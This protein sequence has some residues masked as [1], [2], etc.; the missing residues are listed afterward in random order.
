MPKNIVVL[1]DGTG[2]DGGRGHDSNV[3]KLYRMLEDRTE[4]QIVYY[5]QG[6]GTD[7]RRVSGNAFGVGFTK[8]IEQCYRFIF[9]NYQAGDKIFLFGFSRGAA[10]VRSLASFIH[11][12]GIL[13]KSR[14]TLVADAFKLYG[15]GEKPKTQDDET[16]LE[17]E[18]R[19][20]LQKLAD[21]GIQINNDASYQDYKALRNDLSDKAIQFTTA[22][23]NMWLKS[24]SWVFGTQ[25]LR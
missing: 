2:Q 6:L 21:R 16:F 9:E 11:Y 3:Y 17:E 24:T 23:P 19:K 8:N 4:N 1:S 7:W 14:A 13:P 20:L 15:L 25:S 12:F 10:T 18:T 22:H 5:D